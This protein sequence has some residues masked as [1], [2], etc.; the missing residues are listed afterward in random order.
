MRHCIPNRRPTERRGFMFFDAVI[1]LGLLGAMAAI[2]VIAR[3]GLS[4]VM[5]AS[6][7]RREA[8]RLAETYLIEHAAGRSPTTHPAENVAVE[9]LPTAAPAG[10][11]WVNVR[12]IVNGHAG[13]LAGLV[14]KDAR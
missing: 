9:D 10:F 13:E 12:V 2:L 4:K 14:R 1:S 11:K 5:H 7:D 6:E 8:V 3:G